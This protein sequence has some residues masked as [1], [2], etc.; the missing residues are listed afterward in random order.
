[1]AHQSIIAILQKHYKVPSGIRFVPFATEIIAIVAPIMFFL[2]ATF[3]LRL[4]YLR[5]RIESVDSNVTLANNE[6]KRKLSLEI[7]KGAK[8]D[9]EEV[10]NLANTLASTDRMHDNLKKIDRTI[11]RG[12]FLDLVSIGLLIVV[13]VIAMA[14]AE[15]DSLSILFIGMVVYF[16]L[17]V[18]GSFAGAVRDLFKLEDKLKNKGA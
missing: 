15:F 17:F 4:T 2:T 8:A 10:V 16:V 5:G 6:I 18:V 7:K 12:F 11:R 13:A 1:V 3:T 9:I 14:E